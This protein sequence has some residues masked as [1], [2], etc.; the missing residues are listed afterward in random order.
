MFPDQE[1]V[2]WIV[3]AGKRVRHAITV[4]PGA[5]PAGDPV[6]TLCDATIKLPHETW[7]AT[8]EPSSRRIT[9]RCAECEQ[10]VDE[11]LARDGDLV[12]TT[13]DA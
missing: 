11:Q 7:P 6:Q 9:E 10:A 2:W 12:V 1:H 5:R 3:G 8:K 4:R 13:W